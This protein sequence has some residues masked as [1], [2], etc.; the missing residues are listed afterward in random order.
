MK[1][2]AR[3]ISLTLV[4]AILFFT[5][6][7]S[8]AQGYPQKA[9]RLVVPY[10]PG[11]TTDILAR[12]IG[13]KL[14]EAWGQ[15]IVVEN[16]SGAGGNIGTELVA[17]APPD[18][19]TL[20]MGSIG[21]N[22]VNATLYSKLPY[23]PVKD[24]VPVTQVAWNHLVLVVQPSLQAKSV[25]DLIALA[26]NQPGQLNFAS[27]GNGTS[28][29]LAL[30][31][32][33]A[34]A[35]VDL[36]HIPYRGSGPALIDLMGGRAQGMFDAIPAS[37]PHVKSGKLR[38]LAVASNKRSVVAPDLPTVAEA[39]VPGFAASGW[40]GIFTPGGTPRGIVTKLNAEIVKIL[41]MTEVRDR[42]TKMGSEPVTSTPEEFASFVN[43]E[44]AK[45]AK[46][47]RDAKIR[48]D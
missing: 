8:F 47:V 28:S 4:A 14:T 40:F 26:K 11:G 41:N 48:V 46:V 3:M 16:R 19:Y 31:L 22:A 15:P 36:I 38:A 27:F 23:D 6:T 10:T 24:F 35:G 9:I 1:I 34:M 17:K 20:L 25:K 42:L 21:P 39:G 33:K 5:A 30:E 43:S 32:F 29:H 44:I 2:G 45:W 18:G 12:T 7:G 37:M 13:Q